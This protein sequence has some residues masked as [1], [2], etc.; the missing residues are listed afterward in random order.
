MG[1]ATSRDTATSATNAFVTIRAFDALAAI[2]VPANE[3]G[4]DRIEVDLPLIPVLKGPGQ[5]CPAPEQSQPV[6][7][8][9]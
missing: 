5:N 7:L 9:P 2:I 6:R 8:E 4:L 3:Q 1:D